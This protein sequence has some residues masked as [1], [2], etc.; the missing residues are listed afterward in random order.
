VW[1]HLL[2]QRQSESPNAGLDGAKARVPISVTLFFAL[3]FRASIMKN[4]RT[5][6]IPQRQRVRTYAQKAGFCSMLL[7]ASVLTLSALNLARAQK[8]TFDYYAAKVD[9]AGEAKR[10]GNVEAYHLEQG[11]QKFRARSYDA[12]LGEFE[13]ILGEYPNHPRALLLLAEMCT[14]WKSPR[15]DVDGLFERAVDVN[16]RVSG[17]YVVRGLYY[18]RTGRL[19]N[20]IASYNRALEIDP[21]S[22]NANYNLGLAYFDQK[23]YS[24][25]NEAAQRAYSNG[26]PLPGLRNKLQSVGAWRSLDTGATTSGNEAPSVAAPTPATK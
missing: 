3:S 21:N 18:H 22:L 1:C 19:E 24:R 6:C 9:K 8:T 10:L 13:F 25:A 17:T 5:R 23:Q 12:A 11:D 4:Y 15:C 14:K 26:A 7:A 16:P 20:A 2:Q